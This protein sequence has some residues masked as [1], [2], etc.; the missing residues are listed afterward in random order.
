MSKYEIC[1][2]KDNE[3][4]NLVSLDTLICYGAESSN[5]NFSNKC[6]EEFWKRGVLIEDKFELNKK[7]KFRCK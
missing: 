6:K 4:L 7:R 2:E 5:V 3:I 1:Y